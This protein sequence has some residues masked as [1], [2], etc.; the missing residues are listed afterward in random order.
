MT[1]K[2]SIRRQQAQKTAAVTSTNNATSSSLLSLPTN[3]EKLYVSKM[4]N[5][6]KISVKD[7]DKL[8]LLNADNESPAIKTLYTKIKKEFSENKTVLKIPEL[9]A[10]ANNSRSQ[11]TPRPQNAYILFRKDVSKGLYTLKRMNRSVNYSSKIA[12]YLWQIMKSSQQEYE[13]WMTLYKIVSIKHSETYEGY[14]YRPIRR[15]RNEFISSTLTSLEASSTTNRSSYIVT[16]ESADQGTL[17]NQHPITQI[18]EEQPNTVD[19]IR[20]QGMTT[21]LPSIHTNAPGIMT[22]HQNSTAQFEFASPAPQYVE[23]TVLHSTYAVNSQQTQFVSPSELTISQ[24]DNYFTGLSQQYYQQLANTYSNMSANSFAYATS[25]SNQQK[26]YIQ[27]SAGD[28]THFSFPTYE[29]LDLPPINPR[30]D[31]DFLIA[32]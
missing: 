2:S 11:G 21:I 14:V 8:N 6:L 1:N 7:Q 13:F 23:T 19:P 3:E 18:A 12:S 24:L 10:P 30:L 16:N 22:T 28:T 32:S 20:F 5:E 9:L 31:E 27:Y 4:L 26:Y 17:I 15:K 25:I 29:D